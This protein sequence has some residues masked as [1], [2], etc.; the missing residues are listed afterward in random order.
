MMKTKIL[1]LAL[2]VIFAWPKLYAQGSCPCISNSGIDGSNVGRGNP[3]NSSI[4][5]WWVVSGTPLLAQG[6]VSSDGFKLTNGDGMATCY[7]F[8][9]GMKY[10]VC[11]RAYTTNN[12]DGT[13][14]LET[15]GS[16]IGNV[17]VTQHGL[18]PKDYSITFTAS[19]NFNQLKFLVNTP[20]TSVVIDD[21]GVIEIPTITA[22]PSNLLTCES[23]TLTA[24][25]HNPLT[26]SWWASNGTISS[27]TGTSI[28]ATPC[29]SATYT[30]TFNTSCPMFTCKTD[31]ISINVP[32]SPNGQIVDN[33]SPNCGDFI[34]LQYQPSVPC[35]VASYTWYN[36][37][38][39][40]V[41]SGPSY[42]KN[43]AD[44]LDRGGVYRL[45]VVY[46]NGCDDEFFEVINQNCCVTVADFDINGCNPVR[47]ENLTV[48]GN[49][50]PILNAEWYWDLGDGNT[51][52][53]RNP[54]EWNVMDLSPRTVCLTVV[55][56]DAF[57]TCCDRICKDF[58]PC[59][60]SC[61]PK[62]A[63]D[64]KLLN[65]GTGDVQ[66]YDKS[67][68]GGTPIHWWWTVDGVPVPGNT[69]AN[70]IIAGLGSGTHTVC[71]DVE[72]LQVNGTQSCYEYGWCEEIF[73]P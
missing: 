46:T 10:K 58:E 60:G 62:A 50:D 31:I 64:F 22:S 44:A 7:D 24:T 9:A 69:D 59:D 30:A 5:S 47:F 34:D 73:I 37:S 41:S 4:A 16:S 52:N 40:I 55:A 72:F 29:E 6:V 42:H 38:N 51:S 3:V 23:T 57:S 39:V 48:D 67:A 68:G 27:S 56:S 11:F 65:P 63:F 45:K 12:A 19:A 20:G 54:A 66:L 43:F 14:T 71:L 32:V 49:G 1:L 18:Q 61:D 53:L 25:S 8:Y 21:V 36:P 35:A 15:S 13:V 2:F 28:T 33:S 17:T 26:V 70:P